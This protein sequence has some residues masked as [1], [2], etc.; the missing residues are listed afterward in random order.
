MSTESADTRQAFAFDRPFQE[1]IVQ[2]ML[3]DR[4]WASQMAEVLDVDYFEYAYLRHLTNKYISYYQKFKEFPSL[5]LFITVVKEELASPTD[6]VLNEQMIT[7]IK[8]TKAKKDLGDLQYVK[9]AAMTFCRQQGFK[10][11][12]VKCSELVKSEEQYDRAVEI[13]KKA[14]TAGQAHSPGLSLEDDIDAR[15]SETF[16]NTIKTNICLRDRNWEILDGNSLDSRKILNGGAGS[17]ELCVVIAPTGVGKSH[18]LVHVGA[19]ALLQGKNVLH[20]TFELH[21]RA[22]GVRYDSHL[23]GIDSLECVE[24]KQEIKDFY[25]GS[26]GII[27]KLRIKYFPTGSATVNTL[28]SFI[29]KLSLEGF[30]PDLVVVDYAGI[31]RSTEKYELPR[32]ELKKIYEE[33]RSFAAELDLPIWTACQSNKEGAESEI[34]S[35][36]NMSEAYAQA[37]ICDFV[38]GLGRPESQK[39]TGLGTIFIAKNRNG[40][41]GVSFKVRINTAQSRIS[42]LSEDEV[43]NM[44]AEQQREEEEGMN[45]VRRTF[46]E[47]NTKKVM[48]ADSGL[49]LRPSRKPVEQ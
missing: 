31:M 9:N 6:S 48:G 41:D 4:Q 25:A 19:Q 32:M 43:K 49:E 8:A 21:E 33:L 30:R 39:A 3:T 28:R 12:L 27:G 45:F 24:R 2:A 29:D 14:I 37:H 22:V 15:Y 20:F 46:R 10:N 34:I 42:L 7:V 23:L 44:T 16:R 47:L 11:A 26:V 35:L 36:A 18:F 38:V 40:V 1:K 5:D 13:V 17:G